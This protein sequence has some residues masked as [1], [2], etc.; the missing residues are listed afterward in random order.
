MRTIFIKL[1][2]ETYTTASMYFLLTYTVHHTYIGITA[3]ARLLLHS[4]IHVLELW[5]CLTQ[6]HLRFCSVWVVPIS[7]T[8]NLILDNPRSKNEN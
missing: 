4:I 8:W 2:N 6:I 5:L 7:S 3:T 1:F